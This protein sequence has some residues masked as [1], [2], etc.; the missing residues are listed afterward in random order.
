MLQK[1]TEDAETEPDAS[2]R[3][4]D[5]IHKSDLALDLSTVK[6]RNQ[7]LKSPSNRED[8]SHQLKKS[9]RGPYPASARV[10]SHSVQKPR[11]N[12]TTKKRPCTV[13]TYGPECK[14]KSWPQKKKSNRP[15]SAGRWH[16]SAR[17]WAP[18][19][20]TNMSNLPLSL[21]LHN[22]SLFLS[23]TIH[24]QATAQKY[25]KELKAIIDTSLSESILHHIEKRRQFRNYDPAPEVQMFASTFKKSMKCQQVKELSERYQQH[26]T[27][28][29]ATGPIVDSHLSTPI[30]KFRKTRALRLQQYVKTSQKS[31]QKKNHHTKNVPQKVL[32]LKWLV[33]KISSQGRT[34]Q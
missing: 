25:I 8:K 18:V 3:L 33:A 20:T 7:L 9:C 13:R 11:K 4:I 21:R 2:S 27:R 10:N 34:A 31:P 17:Q 23:Q 5:I 22:N 26:L 19:A 28:M 12:L 29:K 15:T 6:K 16:Q 1:K 24:T 30:Q 14:I 32:H